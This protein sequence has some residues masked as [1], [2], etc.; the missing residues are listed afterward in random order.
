MISDTFMKHGH[1][2][3]LFDLE[4]PPPGENFLLLQS[5]TFEKNSQRTIHLL[6]PDDIKSRF[7]L[8]RG[9]EA[10]LR[11]NDI[12][13]SRCHSV[14]RFTD[15]KYYLEDSQSKFGTLKLATGHIE[16]RDDHPVPLQIGRSVVS[17]AFK[18]YGAPAKL[19]ATFPAKQVNETKP[20]YDRLAHRNMIHESPRKS[21]RNI[22]N[23]DE[24]GDSRNAAFHTPE[25]SQQKSSWN[26]SDI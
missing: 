6:R 21:L 20:M 5:L 8:G 12:S 14:I 16:I 4:L 1:L 7:V 26:L 19:M 3:K 10:D 24:D 2:Y 17:F 18:D 15:Q 25:R 9:H 23:H 13:V 11:V 22:E